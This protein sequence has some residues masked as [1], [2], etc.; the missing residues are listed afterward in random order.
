MKLMNKLFAVTFLLIAVMALLG[1]IF[2]GATWHFATAFMSL[3][4]S[5]L[6][7]SEKEVQKS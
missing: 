4:L 5:W 6:F 7:Y 2:A 1:A 3:F